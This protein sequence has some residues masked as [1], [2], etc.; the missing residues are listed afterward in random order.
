MTD[1]GHGAGDGKSDGGG[2]G[3][4][5]GHGSYGGDVGCDAMGDMGM[6]E[7]T[8]TMVVAERMVTRRGD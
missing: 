6:L 1:G 5:A 4:G 3:G 7:V 2:G 8:L